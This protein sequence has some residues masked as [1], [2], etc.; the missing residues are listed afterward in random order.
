M[1]TRMDREQTFLNAVFAER[2]RSEALLNV[3]VDYRRNFV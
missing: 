1:A 3:A 2:Q